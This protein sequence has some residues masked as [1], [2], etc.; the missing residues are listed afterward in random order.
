MRSALLHAWD[1]G[2]WGR[3]DGPSCEQLVAELTR[4]HGVEHAFLTCSGTAAVELALRAVGVS[5]G[6]HVVLAG[7]D[8][9]GNFRAIEAI[10]ARPVLVDIAPGSFSPTAEHC[11]AAL[12]ADLAKN[13][14]A[15]VLSHLH[16]DLADLAEIMEVARRRGVPVVEDAC[17]ATGARLDDRWAGTIGDIGVISF[18]GSKLLTAGRGGAV[19]TDDAK[20]LQR[21]KIFGERGNVAFPLSELQATVLIPQLATLESDNQRRSQNVRRIRQAVRELPGLHPLPTSLQPQTSFYK[22]A[23]DFDASES[24][25]KSRDQL[26]SALQAE[27]LA[28]G[29]GFRGFARRSTR[30][31]TKV[32][33]L[34]Q[35]L[36]AS[37]RTILL[38][39]P[40]LLE[41]E[42]VID[43]VAFAFR[44]VAC[45]ATTARRG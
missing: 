19:L 39:H 13:V 31:C 3:Y 14:R 37:E 25:W 28:V 34:L 27:G 2:S 36:S 12:A 15:I 22:L 9:P 24:G 16:G 40:V 8:F 42:R 11:Q 20:L 7:Y 1:E 45:S 10:G 26:V 17:Q 6:D 38:H 21:A 29:A 41:P 4:L 5:Q 32:G 23:W 43:R 33:N 44:K 30:R 35:C 18:G